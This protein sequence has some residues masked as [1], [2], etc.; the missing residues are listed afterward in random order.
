MKRFYNFVGLLIHNV[1]SFKVRNNF[2]DITLANG[3]KMFEILLKAF[4]RHMHKTTKSYSA[5]S[6]IKNR[7]GVQNCRNY[8]TL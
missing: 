6:V 4:C 5:V 8:C 7:V 2:K 1:M 3:F